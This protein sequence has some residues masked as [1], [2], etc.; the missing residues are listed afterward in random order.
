MSNPSPADPR[1]I[2]TRDEVLMNWTASKALLETAKADEMSWRKYIVK[3]A[4]PNPDEG[5]NTLDLGNGYEL[6]AVVKYNYKLA[7]PNLVHEAQSRIAKIGN[8]GAFIADRL[9][10]WKVDFLTTEYKNL[11]EEKNE[12]IEAQEILKL[13]NEVLTIEEAAPELKIKE[14]TKK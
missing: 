4:F 7:K 10:S 6:K 13:L 14:P 11:L 8:N 9:F 2:L 3:R 5:T 1:D 12:S